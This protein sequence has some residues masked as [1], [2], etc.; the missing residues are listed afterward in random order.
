MRKH[1]SS[2]QHDPKRFM[3]FCDNDHN[4]LYLYLMLQLIGDAALTKYCTEGKE[5]SGGY[6]SGATGGTPP[7]SNDDKAPKKA[8]ILIDLTNKLV[9]CSATNAQNL[10]NATD[11]FALRNA[12][13]AELVLMQQLTLLQNLRKESQSDEETAAYT[14]K[15]K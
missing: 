14:K 4:Q 7:S 10:K 13:S 11:S 8:R 2:G 1:T 5:I 15:I 9:D 12:A 3:E 6:D